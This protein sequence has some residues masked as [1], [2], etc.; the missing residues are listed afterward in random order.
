MGQSN[1]TVLNGK[2]NFLEKKKNNKKQCDFTFTILINLKPFFLKCFKWGGFFLINKYQGNRFVQN[3]ASI[4]ILKFNVIVEV[5][6]GF[7]KFNSFFLYLWLLSMG[8]IVLGVLIIK[9]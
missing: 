3:L 6:V 2:K 8:L 9:L 4:G 7:V 1:F 5:P